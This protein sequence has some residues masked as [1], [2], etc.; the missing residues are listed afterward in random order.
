MLNSKQRAQLKSLATNEPAI[1]QVGKGGISSALIKQVDDALTARELIKLG[2]LETMEE[3]T[4]ATA[5]AIAEA[6]GAE[7]VKVISRKMI[8]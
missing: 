8:L 4:K 3:S 6:V 1:F 7:A 2:G 5:A